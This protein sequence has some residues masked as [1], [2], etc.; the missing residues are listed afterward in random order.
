MK[1]TVGLF[2]CRAAILAVATAAS[3]QETERGTGLQFLDESTYRSI[4]LAATPLMGN[5][6]DSYDMSARFPTP[7]Y[8]GNQT[9]CVGWAVAYALKS[10][11]EHQERNWGLSGPTRTFSPA[12]IYNQIKLS[13]DCRVGGSL[14][15][16]ALNVLRRDGVATMADFPYQENSCNAVPAAIVKQN[17]RAFA[18]A[19]WRRINVQDEIEVKTQ[20]ASGFPVLIGMMVDRNFADLQAGMIY[21]TPGGAQ[22]GGHAMVV[23]GYSDQR[24][25]FRVINSWGTHWGDGGFGWISYPAFRAKVREAYVVQDIVTT[26]PNPNPGPNPGPDPNPGPNPNPVP[27]PVSVSLLPPTILHNQQ[28]ATP[29]GPQP[30]MRI[31]IQGRL[32]NAQ[33]RTFQLVAHFNYLGGNPLLANPQE[34]LFRDLS[35]LVATGTPATQ[36]GSNDEDLGQIFLTIP[37][38]ALN[39]QPTGGMATYNL[40]FNVV[41]FVNNQPVAQSAQIPFQIRW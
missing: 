26:Q 1:R 7:G 4:P 14:F 35:G 12:F 11:Q 25:A 29:I 15:T 41:A 33:G 20:L 2:C 18:V 3:A 9:S 28:V 36:V 27:A 37:Y 16:D 10:Y 21:D 31:Q 6:P 23:V 8:Q 40:S 22:L 19:D 24:N 30:G 5:L 32:Q 39:F 34:P 17:A 13:P 38:Y